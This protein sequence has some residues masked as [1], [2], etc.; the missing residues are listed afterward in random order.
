M[1]EQLLSIAPPPGDERLRYGAGPS[2]FLDVRHGAG[3]GQRPL[4]VCL[5]GGYWRARYD[6]THLG[7]L[8]AGLAARGFTT[9]NIEYRRLG[10]PGVGFPEM[11]SDVRAA[12]AF[13]EARFGAV[14]PVVVGH[15]AGGHLAL[16]AG[17]EGLASRVVA[18]APVSDLAGASRLALS[19]GVADELLATTTLAAASPAHRLPVGCPVVLLHGTA[20]DTVP[21]PMSEAFV[22]KATASGG[23]VRLVPLQGGGHY[24]LID[25]GS[26]AFEAVVAALG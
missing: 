17:R 1:S 11:S 15:S 12:F 26:P 21:Y 20:D 9:A 5:H 25:P 24:E 2:Q 14:W 3:S 19:D 18:L 23:D 22:Q 6:L 8:C 10:E 13:L 16:W 4:V 7:H